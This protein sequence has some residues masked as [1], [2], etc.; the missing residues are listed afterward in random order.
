MPSLNKGIRFVLVILG[1]LTVVCFGALLGLLSVS[2]FRWR[3]EIVRL[4]AV[5]ALPD[6]SWKELFDLN[7]HGDPFNLK[8]LVT[9]PSPYLV[10]QNPFVSG[11]DIAAGE[12]I[13]QSN[14]T[15]CHGSKGVGGSLGPALKQ[16][17]MEKG[18]S[19]WAIFKTI[20]Q[21]I[22]GT[23]M[24]PS[25]L[26]LD[27]RWRIVAYV[28]MLA[29]GTE[30]HSASTLT[31][32]IANLGSVSYEDILAA[33]QDTQRW[34]TYSGSY[35]G[36]RFSPNDQIN[37]A[38]ASSLRLLWMRQYTTSEPVIE[39]SPLIV[40][41]FMFITVPPNRVEALDARTG[42]PIWGYD[43]PLPP[44]MSLCCGY[45]NR[46]LAVLGN[47]LFLGTLDAHLVAL[48]IRTGRVVWD[49][50]VADYREGYSITSAP[51]ALKNMVVTG[52]AGGEFGIRGFVDARDAATG[53]QIWR[54]DTIPRQGEP[55]ADTWEADALKTGGGPTW[56]TGTFDPELKLL[57]WPV[58]NPSPNYNGYTR[59]GDN[60]YT[61]SV[62]AL[63]ADHGNL[64]WHFQFTPHDTHDWDATEILILFDKA[65]S[66]Q[67]ERLLAQANRN[68]FYYVLDRE[69]GLFRMAHPFAKQTWAK[70]IDSH[71]RPVMNPAALPTPEGSTVYPSVGGASNWPS[72]S[73]SPITGL[74]YV[75]VREWGGIF[76]SKTVEH[77]PGDLFLGG[78]SQIFTNPPTEA[79]VR[80]LDASTGELRWEYRNTT[81]TV[82]GLLSTKGGVVFGSAAQAFFALDATTGREL[83]RIETGGAIG[84]APVSYS[85]G[86]RQFVTIAAGHDLLTFGLQVPFK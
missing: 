76:F 84:A 19:D 72:P 37:K 75:P 74:M 16:R 81:D 43:R 60:L 4:K 12:R 54:F 31:S 57:Y 59:K 29:E 66:G 28:K 80:A 9:T 52:V 86:G 49:V 58:G 25:S 11:E 22:A 45:V 7:R 36:H 34:L 64:R 61:N 3:A 83:W 18:S 33:G 63:D 15:L 56:L 14:C 30:A 6:I 1:I 65:V 71:G 85:I 13:F 35:D 79:V 42:A 68:A 39:T 17:Q 73:Y 44:H 55:G 78:S 46:G 82:G 62:V 47:L 5:G 26:P 48:D 50:E 70:E 40:D 21:G 23:S 53:K 41:G 27:D 24:P 8:E 77:H 38:N 51:L 69:N 10:I 20:S 2:R 67:H 32:P